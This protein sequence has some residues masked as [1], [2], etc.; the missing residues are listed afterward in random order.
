M[1]TQDHVMRVIG[2][3]GLMLGKMRS[4]VS[5]ISPTQMVLVNTSNMSFQN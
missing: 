2:K 4:V 5:I 3:S 1:V